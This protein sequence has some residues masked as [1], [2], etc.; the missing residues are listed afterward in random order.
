[1]NNDPTPPP[2]AVLPPDDTTTP[3]PSAPVGDHG[4]AREEC[5]LS[6]AQKRFSAQIN[7]KLEFIGELTSHLNMLACVELCVVYY[8]DCSLFRLL[9]RG[10]NQMVF[11]TPRPA[12]LQVDMIVHRP[13]TYAIFGP[14]IL[15]M[16]LHMFT[17]RSEAGETMR[18]YLHGGIIIDLIGQKGPTSKLHLVFLDCLILMLQCVML[19]AVVERERLSKVMKAYATP[20]VAGNSTRAPVPTMQ[21]HDAEELG[22]VRDAE[23]ENGDIEL[24]PLP[25]LTN[26]DSIPT[27]PEPALDIEDNDHTHL[28]AEPPPREERGDGLDTFW[29]GRV[30]IADFHVLRVIRRHW[31]DYGLMNRDSTGAALQNV[32]FRAEVAALAAN[33]GLRLNPATQQRFQRDVD[34]LT[35]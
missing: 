9:L 10:V 8:M 30:I 11:L 2:A 33:R 14:N 18:G 26:P 17:A 31:L 35:N 27:S 19:A 24:Q 29:S 25:S 34:A 20:N 12:A 21:D 3:A 7:K 6:P 5:A 4:R 1:M 28:L 32:G 15:C 22:V 23:T 16:L 13:F